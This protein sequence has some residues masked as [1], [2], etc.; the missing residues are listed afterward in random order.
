[1]LLGSFIYSLA[2]AKTHIESKRM[3]L[4]VLKVTFLRDSEEGRG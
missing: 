4:L 1:M 3:R 2:S